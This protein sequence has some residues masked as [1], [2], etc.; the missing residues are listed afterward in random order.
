MNSAG[1]YEVPD[2]LWQRIHFVRPRFKSNIENVLL[3]MA[4][5]CC[6]IPRCS[7]AEYNKRYLDAIRRFPG[8][9]SA[10]EKTLQNWRTEI[11]ALFGF[12]VEKKDADLTWTSAM[13]YFLHE[14]QD[15]IQFMRIFLYSFQFPGG[16]LKP[17]DNIELIENRVRFKPCRC[18]L[19]VLLAGNEILSARGED[20]EMSL[21]AEEV[22]YCIFNDLR[23]TRGLM[24]PREI[25]KQIL[26]NRKKKLKYY[27]KYDPRIAG[28]AGRPRS[29]G[30]VTRYAADILDYMELA[31]LVETRHGHYYLNPMSL[32]AIKRYAEDKSWFDGYDKFYRS[33]EIDASAVACVE[34]AWYQYVNDQLDPNLFKTEIESLF[35][36]TPELD[37]VFDERI[38]EMIASD[39]HTG[40]D[41]GNLGEAIV[42]GH[43]RKRLQ[44]CGYDKFVRL[45]RI[46]D[47]AKYHPGYDIDSYEADGT[48]DLRMIEVKTT[49][50]KRHVQL[51]GFHLTPNEWRRA[52]T[53]GR[54]YYVYRLMLSDEKKTLYV[55]PNPVELYKQNKIAAE[56]R[57]GMDVIFDEKNFSE[58]EV[59][60]WKN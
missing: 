20:K 50:S 60:A 58:T 2:G 1:Y 59:L 32:S 18:I 29:K 21:S 57:D 9:V 48:E 26:T 15:L 40:K 39:E 8:N 34:P 47:S 36:K 51:Y 56:L 5:E 49:I 23:S 44:E 28:S 46:A 37:V 6:R 12:Y 33:A 19:R 54:H 10:T 55:L 41:I 7:C 31:Q 14:Q 25:A 52:S 30:D 24:S 11:P 35:K 42:I 17:K 16:H 43:E 13:A 45:V 27:N 3:Y 53:V 4:S 22:T 38:R